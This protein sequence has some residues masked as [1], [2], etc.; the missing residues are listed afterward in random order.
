[1]FNFKSLFYLLM[2][3]LLDELNRELENT[4]ITFR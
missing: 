3:K 2:S 1:M 4:I